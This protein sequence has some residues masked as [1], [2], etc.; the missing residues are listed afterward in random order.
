M[1]IQEVTNAMSSGGGLDS[2]EQGLHIHPALSELI[3]KTLS[4]IEESG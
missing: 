4:N 2:I 1:L 3:P